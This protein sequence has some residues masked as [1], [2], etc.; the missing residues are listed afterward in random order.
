MYQFYDSPILNYDLFIFDFD[1]TLMDT[2]EYHA[3]SW[4]N[5]LSEYKNTDIEFSMESDSVLAVGCLNNDRSVLAK[6][7]A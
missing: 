7:Y 6:S 4:K 3:L 2:E 1:G 5:A